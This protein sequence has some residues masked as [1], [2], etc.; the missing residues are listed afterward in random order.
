MAFY[1]DHPFV[2]GVLVSLVG[3]PILIFAAIRYP[4]VGAFIHEYPWWIRFAAYTAAIFPLAI[5][6]FRPHHASAAFWTL[7]TALFVTHLVFF[8]GVIHY[9]RQLT[10][11]DYIF[12]GPFEGLAFA[13]LIPRAMHVLRRRHA[14]RSST[15]G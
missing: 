13:I 5:T 12:W 14:G 8:V 11:F 15:P 7:I 6:Y 3:M 10:S 9:V 2:F 1:R 4:S